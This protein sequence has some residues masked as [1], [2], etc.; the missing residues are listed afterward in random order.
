MSSL[1]DEWDTTSYNTWGSEND[2]ALT[3][4][5]YNTNKT[6]STKGSTKG[7]NAS[8][9]TG[10]NVPSL[11]SRQHSDSSSVE[12][13]R[14]FNKEVLD[15]E[16]DDT[17]DKESI[18]L[19]K[20]NYSWNLDKDWLLL[21]NQSTLKL[22]CNPRYIKNIRTVIEKLAVRTISRTAKTN[23]KCNVPGY[24]KA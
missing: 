16:V 18:F 22:M 3:L 19:S 5:G 24:G 4:N 23:Q 10:S 2:Q 12:N 7:S 13:D 1:D 9:S 8:T 6:S 21:D 11:I 14:S 20:K 17:L 15:S